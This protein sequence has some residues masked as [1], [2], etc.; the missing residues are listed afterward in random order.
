MM[1]R[2]QVHKRISLAFIS[3]TLTFAGAVDAQ[4]PLNYDE[5]N[6]GKSLTV[7]PGALVKNQYLPDPFALNG[8][9]RV[10]T[11]EDWSR[12]RNEIK[13]E[14]E[15]YEIGK[16]P[17]KPADLTATYSG[18]VL[19]VVVKENGKTVTLSSKF[20]IP[21]G[22]GPHPIV[23]GMNA[24][25][26]TLGTSLFPGVAQVPFMHNDAAT[27]VMS[28]GKDLNAP[29]YKMY[30]TLQTNGDYSA[31]SWGVSR[32]IDGLELIAKAQN[33]DMTRIAVTGCSY[34]GK[35]A[36]FAGAFDERVTLTIAQE[37]GGGGINSWRAADIY[38]KRV[39]DIEKINNTSGLW[40]MQSM[41]SLDP[42]M[43]PH[44]HHELIGMIAP[45]AILALGNPDYGWLGD[46][47][48]YKSVM[49]AKEIW[50]AMS[51]EDRFGFDFA[52]GHSHCAASASQ[53]KAVAAFVDKFLLK[54]TTNTNI[55]IAPVN[56]KFK[57]DYASLINWPTPKISSD[58]GIPTI[59]ISSPTGASFEAPATITITATATDVDGTIS[60]V[61][62]Y[63]GS[64]LL[65]TVTKAPYTFE[66]KNVAIGSYSLKAVATDNDGKTG[67]A[68]VTA[69]VT[70]PR[71]A[72]GGTS[73]AIPG[74]IEFEN[75]DEGGN[76][77]A[78]LDNAP[79]SQTNVSFRPTE[80]VDIETC[81]D[82]GAGYNV[83]YASVGE[84]LEYTVNVAKAGTYNIGIRVACN[85]NGRTLSLQANGKK[86]G[87]DVSVPNTSGW[88]TWQ[89]VSLKDIP[90]DAGK[91]VIRVTIGGADYVNLN[92][93]EFA[94][95]NETPTRSLQNTGNS[96][97]HIHAK[98]GI[99]NIQG[100]P[101]GS[102]IRV[103]DL[104]GHLVAEYNNEGG[105]LPQNAKGLLL[106]QV[107]EPSGT[108]TQSKIT[109]P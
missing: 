61:E 24:G 11:F 99:L 80:D 57:L 81:T 1:N 44:D 108:L 55:G 75:Y 26:G 4:P 97:I 36:L 15:K 35:M 70:G 95:V 101:T 82:V 18:G 29:F 102:H 74:K 25:T 6:T 7:T 22:A 41:K 5:E 16:K 86:L 47:A 48:G 53:N 46:E 98:A 71:T 37:S 40:F 78:Y 65:A 69:V 39:E 49:A 106:V 89:T 87:T 68:G 105:R 56:S 79:G 58:I 21:S 103:Y 34:A 31:W 85:G 19:T 62:F 45:R 54:K 42:Y 63:N 38:A 51:I 50:K 10:A 109:N 14:I 60:K 12:R 107:E 13:S 23:I 84:W 76:G 9:G 2:K 20:A 104:S 94:L 92:Y 17:D 100:A 33:L 28:G 91:Q 43:L 67:Q 83:G 8:G 77:V 96:Q 52:G 73:W 88:Q 66:W 64:D 30:P 72:Y 59:S 27:Y 32:L 3:L 93:M 90:L